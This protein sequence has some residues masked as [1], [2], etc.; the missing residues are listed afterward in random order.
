MFFSPKLL[1][2]FWNH[3]NSFKNVLVDVKYSPILFKIA[4]NHSH[5]AVIL[6]I[7]NTLCNEHEMKVILTE[8]VWQFHSSIYR[9]L[10]KI[11]GVLCCG[12]LWASQIILIANALQ[13]IS[14]RLW[15][16]YYICSYNQSQ[17][18]K[19]V[20]MYI[21]IPERRAK[22]VTSRK[23]NRNPNKSDMQNHNSPQV[24]LKFHDYRGE[25]L[26]RG[27]ALFLPFYVFS[28]NSV[29]APN[30]TIIPI[31]DRSRNT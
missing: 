14:V 18:L 20:N 24:P 31:K 25:W 30:V 17:S 19:N 2:G 22:P 4:A 15:I 26:Y 1:P 11:C 3:T 21:F 27:R 23:E 12:N 8:Y 5:Y 28:Y 13:N 29:L 10:I 16:Y 9:E 6:W 7:S